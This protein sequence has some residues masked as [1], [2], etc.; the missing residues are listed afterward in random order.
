MQWLPPHTALTISTI[1]S[2]KVKV[3][4]SWWNVFFDI[5]ITVEKWFPSA[6]YVVC[7]A[8]KMKQLSFNTL[9]AHNSISHRTCPFR[10]A[11]L[12]FTQNCMHTRGWHGNIVWTH[13]SASDHHHFIHI[14]LH[15]HYIV[16]SPT[17]IILTISSPSPSASPPVCLCSFIIFVLRPISIL[18]LLL[19]I[20][21]FCI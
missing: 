13:A 10:A 7:K 17:N 15:P 18:I 8:I 11:W 21:F 9:T 20:L 19:C 1:S 12:H 16:A 5:D 3:N 6:W 4:V 2:E 14:P